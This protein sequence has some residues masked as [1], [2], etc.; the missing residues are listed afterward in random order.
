MAEMTRAERFAQAK[1]A[2]ELAQKEKQGY[3][4]VD[5]PK[6]EFEALTPN[7]SHI[8]RLIGNALEMATEPTD[9]I[10]VEK[11]LIMGD[12]GNYFN[13]IWSNDKDHPMR[14][15]MRTILG[16]YTWDA[17]KKCRIYENADIPVFKKFMTNG[18]ENPSP[19]ST[20]MLPQKYILIN[21]ITRGEND[22]W[23]KDNKHTKVLCWDVTTKEVN[24]ETK[25]YPTWGVKP[26]LYKEVFDTKCTMLNRHF[27]D[28]DFL[29][30]RY[31]KKTKPSNDVYLSVVTPE[32]KS[33]I[34]NFGE[35]EG[36]DFLSYINDDYLS[37]EEE[38]YE[39][40]V[41][42]DIPFISAPTPCS[43]ILNKLEKFIKEVD[44]EFGTNHYGEF[45]EFKAKELEE[46]KVKSAEK[47]HE[48]E[49]KT[50]TETSKVEE[51]VKETVVEVEENDLPTEVEEPVVKKIV[52]KT[53]AETIKSFDLS[54]Y[55]D[56]FPALVNL[57]DSEKSMI[58]G[59]DE[60]KGEFKFNTTDIAEC[61]CGGEIPDIYSSCPYCGA[62][63]E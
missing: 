32:E 14:K 39:R 17:E 34:R 51:S 12:D 37:K 41:L 63:F 45:V 9:P 62:R 49:S 43:V 5:V 35:K 28:T 23:C 27:E 2:R 55:Y 47:K 42:K 1:K 30:K 36:K 40:Y 20:G 56:S 48:E 50:V 61:P 22:T 11:S 24:G 46:L 54:A 8:V 3:G 10:Q 15:L 13:V 58:I 19:F 18:V 59:V 53:V 60:N 33:V 44:A 38:S 26:S 21:C 25:V 57:T 31:D 52:K 6:M 7:T 29:I 4:S 16:K